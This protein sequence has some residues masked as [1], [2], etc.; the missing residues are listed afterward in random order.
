MIPIPFPTNNV[1]LGLDWLAWCPRVQGYQPNDG[2]QPVLEFLTLG[3]Q[4][5]GPAAISWL[6]AEVRPHHLGGG[7]PTTQETRD[8]ARGIGRNNDDA[9]HIIGN[10][11]G[12]YGHAWWNIFPQTPNINR[13]IYAADVERLIHSLVATQGTAQIW[14]R[15]N[16]GD[17]LHPLRATQVNFFVRGGQGHGDF[18]NDEVPNP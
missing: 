6:Y 4:V 8:Y 1:P 9:G 18:Y 11:Q 17:A 2:N 13:G 14:F 16:F 7:T 5:S 12:G 10:N 15:F 3:N